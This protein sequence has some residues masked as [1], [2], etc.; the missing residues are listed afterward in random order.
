MSNIVQVVRAVEVFAMRFLNFQGL[1]GKGDRTRY[2]VQDSVSWAT[3]P[4]RAWK[5][6]G[7][8][9]TDCIRVSRT[10][11]SEVVFGRH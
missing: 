11:V 2:P 6:L 9:C 7:N 10:L 5:W 3:R 4:R 1:A 8:C